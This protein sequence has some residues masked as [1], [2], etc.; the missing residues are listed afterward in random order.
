MAQGYVKSLN[1]LEADTEKDRGIFENIGGPGITNDIQLFSGNARKVEELYADDYEID[2]NTVV[3]TGDGCIAFSNRTLVYHNTTQYQVVNSNALDRFQLRTIDGYSI[4]I[5]TGTL[6]RSD[7]VT[8]DNLSNMSATRLEVNRDSSAS[9]TSDSVGVNDETGIYNLRSI[10]ENYDIIEEGI[11]IYYYK[12]SR[13]P[14]TYEESSFDKR[15]NFNGN[16]R[17]TNVANITQSESSPGLFIKGPAGS[18]RAFSDTS[19]PWS[20]E[21]AGKLSTTSNNSAVYDLVLNE[22]NLVLPTSQIHSESGSASNYTHK[23]KVSVKS[24]SH[25]DDATSYETYYILLST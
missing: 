7:Y 22:P 21:I 10:S 5:P 15:I 11:G 4:F 8:F 13:I 14:L 17:I 1:L 23:M 2:G 16:I 20:D 3:V 18:V 19:N 24:G 25:E 9:I 6:T 12:K